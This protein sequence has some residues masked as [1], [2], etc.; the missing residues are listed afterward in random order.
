MDDC[1]HVQYGRPKLGPRLSFY[2][3]TPSLDILTK[4]FKRCDCV[5]VQYGRPELGPRRG[6][7]E[8]LIENRPEFSK[9]SMIANRHQIIPTR[10]NTPWPMMMKLKVMMMMVR[11]RRMTVMMTTT[12]VIFL[13]I[14]NRRK[15]F[16]VM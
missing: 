6:G 2:T 3:L 14:A 13:M 5:H 8:R 7:D 1:V 11:R 16:L 4:A 12:V 9:F 10:V 15:I